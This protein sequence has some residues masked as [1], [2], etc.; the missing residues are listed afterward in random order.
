MT[1]HT[2]IANDSNHPFIDPLEDARK[3]LREAQSSAQQVMR[4]SSEWLTLALN[5]A[6][7]MTETAQ[8]LDDEIISEPTEEAI[9]ALQVGAETFSTGV[10]EV[11]A[12]TNLALLRVVSNLRRATETILNY[13]GA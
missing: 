8:H 9:A 2:E 4:D 6:N 1:N 7:C 10:A 13:E 3:L 12:R 5:A 11:V